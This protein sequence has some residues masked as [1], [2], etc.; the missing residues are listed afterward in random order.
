MRIILCLLLLLGVSF[1]AEAQDQKHIVL[2]K[3]AFKDSILAQ[4][5]VILD[6]RRA[7]EFEAGH[8]EKALNYNVLDSIN[9]RIQVEN[10]DTS[11]PVYLYCRSG[12]RSGK[13]A[14]IMQKMGFEK[15]YDLKGGYLGWVKEDS[16]TP[17]NE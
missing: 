2:E 8:L 6:V 3:E 14:V 11:K 12:N 1:Q 13:A 4:D 7:E 9:F 10:L 15:L 5:V 16:V 17:K